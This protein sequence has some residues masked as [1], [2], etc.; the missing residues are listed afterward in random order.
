M[1]VPVMGM[2][3]KA[4]IAAA[5]KQFAHLINSDANPVEYL[6]TNDQAMKSRSGARS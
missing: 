1:I 2:A 5:T 6:M 3:N 4:E